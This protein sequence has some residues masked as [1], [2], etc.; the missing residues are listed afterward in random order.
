MASLKTSG[1]FSREAILGYY[2]KLTALV[3]KLPSGLQKPILQQLVPIRELFLEQRPPRI[4]FLGSSEKDLVEF[5]HFLQVPNFKFSFPASGWSTCSRPGPG[6]SLF[7]ET[8]GLPGQPLAAPVFE[9]SAPDLMVLWLEAGE[10]EASVQSRL[11]AWKAIVPECPVVVCSPTAAAT[12]HLPASFGCLTL[13]ED[14]LAAIFAGLPNPAKLEWC[15]LVDDKLA[16]AE[17]ASSLLKSFSATCGVIGMQPIPLAD[18][19]VLTGIQSLM[20]SLIVYTSGRAWQPA[21]IAQFAAALGLNL[22]AA[23]AFREGARALMKF[24]PVWG[25]AVSGVVAGSGTYAI[26]RAAIAHF[27]EELP[28]QESRKIFRRLKREKQK[29]PL[30]QLEDKS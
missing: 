13:R 23:F 29:Q 8:R 17:V 4:L 21:L 20:I 27:I 18:L 12:S 30:L 6:Q 25:N 19:P 2:D 22:G 7:Y 14:V 3:E 10:S 5:L 26:G 24:V 28:V 16:K 15:W 9:T 11:E 1:T